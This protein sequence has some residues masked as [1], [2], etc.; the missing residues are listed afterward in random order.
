MHDPMDSNGGYI[1]F[2]GRTLYR[3]QTRSEFKPKYGLWEVTCKGASPTIKKVLP[4][5]R[6]IKE[7]Y[8][9]LSKVSVNIKLI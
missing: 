1:L 7:F 6:I 9:F 4:Y 8:A 5:T 3:Q 2:T